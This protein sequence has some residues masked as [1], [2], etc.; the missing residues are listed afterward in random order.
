MD[1]EDGC[2]LKKGRVLQEEVGW[3]DEEMMPTWFP[4]CELN[5]G[6]AAEQIPAWKV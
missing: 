5:E 4:A 2:E 3:V 6:S 1:L